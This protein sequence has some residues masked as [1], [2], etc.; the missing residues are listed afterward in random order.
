VCASARDS[1]IAGGSIF[2]KKRG[3]ENRVAIEQVEKE[4]RWEGFL[5][6]KATQRQT[7]WVAMSG[8]TAAVSSS[9][10]LFLRST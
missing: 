8:K 4:D 9:T 6:D 1:S 10:W 7:S 5:A 3:E 2:K